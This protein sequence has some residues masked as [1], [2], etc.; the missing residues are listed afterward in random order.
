MLTYATIETWMPG[1][2]ICIGQPCDYYVLNGVG[3]VKLLLP[4]LKEYDSIHCYLDND[5]AGRTATKTIPLYR[6]DDCRARLRQSPQA[7]LLER[8]GQGN[9]RRNASPTTWSTSPRLCKTGSTSTP[10][11]RIPTASTTGA[12]RARNSRTTTPTSMLCSPNT[13]PR[14]KSR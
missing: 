4:Y 2:G 8:K 13:S 1:T 5:D 9:P 3:E 6:S 11:C 12:T 14:R 7:T 10:R